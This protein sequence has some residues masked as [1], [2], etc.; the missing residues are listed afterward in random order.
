VLQ[1]VK[2]V[3]QTICR[4]TFDPVVQEVHE[5]RRGTCVTTSKAQGL[6]LRIDQIFIHNCSRMSENK[7]TVTLPSSRWRLSMTQRVDDLL[8]CGLLRWFSRKSYP[9]S[10]AELLNLPK[11]EQFKFT[12]VDEGEDDVRHKN[13]SYIQ[14]NYLF[15]ATRIDIGPPA[16]S[17]FD[18]ITSRL[19]VVLPASDC[20]WQPDTSCTAYRQRLGCRR[21]PA[22]HQMLKL[23]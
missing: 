8:Y 11:S 17:F 20:R 12:A 21:R 10:T 18:F 19:P 14:A 9:I 2:I 1:L 16:T 15:M 23:G 3:V 4:T 5:K 7:V 22:R 6:I 13:S